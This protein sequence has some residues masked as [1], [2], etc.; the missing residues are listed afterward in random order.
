M[1]CPFCAETIRDEALVC[2]HCTRDLVLVRPIIHEIQQLTVEID[3]LHRELSRV[4]LKLAATKSPGRF[5]LDFALTYIVLPSALLIAAHYLLTFV[6]DA[7]PL[8]LRVLSILIPLPFGFA[9]AAVK[10]LGFRS[11]VMVGVATSVASVWSMLVVTSHFDDVPVMPADWLEWKETFEYGVSIMLAYAAGNLLGY[12]LFEAL[13][14]TL[15]SSGKPSPAA[16]WIAR[17][18]GQRAGHE[19]L[20]RRARLLQ[21]II[22]TAGPLIG[23]VATTCGSLYAGLKGFLAN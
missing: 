21:D 5:L 22:R 8:Y 19:A 17:A 3:A 15:I 10:N 18:W 14:R 9:L 4:R 23:L 1:E 2:K 16:Y 11:A 12:I 6:L 7:A 20:R 13:P